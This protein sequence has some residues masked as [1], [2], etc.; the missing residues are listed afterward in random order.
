[1]RMGEHKVRPIRINLRILQPELSQ[2][3]P[4]TPPVGGEF[5]PCRPKLEFKKRKFPS[6]GRG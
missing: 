1:M 3:P 5:T 6:N 4:L 2:N